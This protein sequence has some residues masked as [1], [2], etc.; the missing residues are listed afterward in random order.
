MIGFP[1]SPSDS[2][3]IVLGSFNSTHAGGGVRM[4]FSCVRLAGHATVSAETE[5]QPMDGSTTRRVSLR[6][7][8]EAVAMMRLL[9]SSSDG[10][11]N[12]VTRLHCRAQPNKRLQQPGAHIA[13]FRLPLR[14]DALLGNARLNTSITAPAA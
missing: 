6:M 10:L 4:T 1:R 12:M 3:E 2:R 9:P 8:V 11:R 13:A 5:D 7:P 14:P